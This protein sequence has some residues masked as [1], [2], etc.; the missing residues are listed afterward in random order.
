MDEN[1]ISGT[2]AYIVCLVLF[3]HKEDILT[4]NCVYLFKSKDLVVSKGISHCMSKHSSRKQTIV[5][6]NLKHIV[7]R[8]THTH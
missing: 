2:A 5:T 4:F 3:N 6:D 1:L 7:H 8:H